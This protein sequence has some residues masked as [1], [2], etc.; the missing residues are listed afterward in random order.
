M[1]KDGYP[2]FI[3][4]T[5]ATV[6]QTEKAIEAGA[7]HATHF[8]DVFPY[9]GEKDPGVRTCGAVEAILANPN[10]SVDFVLDGEHVHPVAVKV[11]LACKGSTKVSL[12]TDANVNAGLPPGKYYSFKGYG[13]EVLYE[14]GPA[15]MSEDSCMPG[16]LVGSGLTM[17]RAVR[18]AI[19]FL[20]VNIPQAVAMG[21]SN[22]VRVLGLHDRKG[23]IKE[24]YDADLIILDKELKVMRC[25]VGGKCYFDSKGNK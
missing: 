21:S 7:V 12:I 18:N 25:W 3:T 4:H 11:A 5:M 8:Y 17:D 2:A 24:G 15:R 14:G 23:F 16:S 13:V 1:V 22:P 10:T 20:G 9:P 19:K 6:E